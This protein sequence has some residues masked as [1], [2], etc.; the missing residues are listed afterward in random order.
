MGVW[1]NFF[2]RY[3]GLSQ[4]FEKSRNHSTVQPL[5]EYADVSKIEQMPSQLFW[6]S[7]T[8]IGLNYMCT[9]FHAVSISRID[10]RVGGMIYP[11][12]AHG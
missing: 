4:T 7:P 11:P 5:I 6:C 10:F 9:K 12:P 2:P 8:I 1:I 3:T